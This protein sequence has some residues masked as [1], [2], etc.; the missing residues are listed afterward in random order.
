MRVV[1]EILNLRTYFGYQ[2]EEGRYI[3]RK[4]KRRL[5]KDEVTIALILDEEEAVA[6]IQNIFNFYSVIKRLH[7]ERSNSL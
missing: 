6:F 5:R 7:G 2:G 4:E 3:A 1:L